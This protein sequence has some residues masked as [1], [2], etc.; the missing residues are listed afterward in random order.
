MTLISFAVESLGSDERDL[1]SAGIKILHSLIHTQLHDYSREQALS[2]IQNSP[3]VIEH[4]F[5]V[6][7][8]TRIEDRPERA[9][10][11]LIIAKLAGNL[12]VSGFPYAMHSLRSLLE[13]SDEDAIVTEESNNIDV[14]LVLKGL[15]I[16]QQLAC[17]TCNF[18]AISNA[19]EIML[20]ITKFTRYNPAMTAI[21]FEKA[22]NSLTA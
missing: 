12:C 19:D 11:T 22:R 14:N 21:D 10:A 1:H 15:E 8:R 4:L 3:D 17:N 13:T 5:K 16:L 18:T 7:T 20:K 6:I 2:R 9:R